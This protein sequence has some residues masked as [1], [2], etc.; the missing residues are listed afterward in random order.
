MV[1]QKFLSLEYG[2]KGIHLFFDNLTFFN[3][4]RMHEK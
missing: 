4:A 1:N 2:C 3:K